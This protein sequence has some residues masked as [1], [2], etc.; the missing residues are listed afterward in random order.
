MTTMNAIET[1]AMEKAIADAAS[2]A[3]RAA[4]VPGS[5]PVD[6][7]VRV[8]GTVTVAPDTDKAGTSKLLT[9][10]FVMLALYMAGCTRERAAEIIRS[11]AGN[12]DKAARAATVEAFDADGTVRGMFATL[13]AAVPRTP[14]RGSVKFVGDVEALGA[15]EQRHAA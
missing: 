1:L 6:M 2:K 10:E 8:V 3:A 14:V 7:L 13:K 5:Y 11:L 9:E 4:V 12:A 15:V